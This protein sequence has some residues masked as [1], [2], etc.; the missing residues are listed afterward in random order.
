MNDNIDSG[1]VSPDF[2][3]EINLKKMELEKVKVEEERLTNRIRTLQQNLIDLETKET[4]RLSSFKSLYSKEKEILLSGVDE[5]KREKS[6]LEEKNSELS[7]TIAEKETKLLNLLSEL[8]TKTKLASS[9]DVYLP[10][11][12]S[13]IHEKEREFNRIL[14]E[15]ELND[16]KL[17]H[18]SKRLDNLNREFEIKRMQLDSYESSLSNTQQLLGELEQ[19]VAKYDGLKNEIFRNIKNSI[20]KENSLKEKIARLEKHLKSLDANRF[21]IESNL[22]IAEE[23]FITMVASFKEEINSIK[24][25]HREIS[26]KLIDK[27]LTLFKKTEEITKKE[28]LLTGLELEFRAV[29][30][31]IKVASEEALSHSVKKLKLQEEILQLTGEKIKLENS[32]DS[33]LIEIEKAG[34]KTTD[35]EE[36]FVR[37]M[38]N[39]RD[40]IESL[41]LARDAAQNEYTLM[42]ERLQLLRNDAQMSERNISGT[43]L[44]TDQLIADRDALTHEISK[45]IELKSKL[46][47]SASIEDEIVSDS[48]DEPTKDMDPKPE[49]VTTKPVDRIIPPYGYSGIDKELLSYLSSELEDFGSE[50]IQKELENLTATLQEENS[51]PSEPEIKLQSPPNADEL[52]D[53]IKKINENPDEK[54]EL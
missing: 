37:V 18:L 35:T 7:A 36:S 15:I 53:L 4:S 40:E 11:L 13:S 16:E 31:R 26:K 39:F 20:Q 54:E 1:S 8:S 28:K 17:S 43:I 23:N 34:E 41:K 29:E 9:L 47:S 33:L 5:L 22:L 25:K 10:Q 6:E 21:D 30:Y 24:I 46:E 51:E 3:N 42:E 27:E 49:E 19:K 48:S 32:R 12:D 14:R 2:D 45:L 44:E 38:Q 50:S 52:K